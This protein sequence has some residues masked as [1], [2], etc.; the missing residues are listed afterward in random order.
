MQNECLAKRYN[1]L[2]EKQKKIIKESIDFFYSIQKV[3]KKTNLYL[4]KSVSFESDFL[5]GIGDKR[6]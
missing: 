2:N 3:D 5:V 4:V 1:F 6:L